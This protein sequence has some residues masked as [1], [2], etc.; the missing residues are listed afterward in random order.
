M[1]KKIQSLQKDTARAQAAAANLQQRL[2]AITGLYREEMAYRLRLQDEYSA[3]RGHLFAVLKKAMGKKAEFLVPKSLYEQ[4]YS[5]VNI[6]TEGDNFKFEFA[7]VE[8]PENAPEPEDH[9][10]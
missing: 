4:E 1:S 8:V 7:P 9:T 5:G 2:A 3:L 6:R 10:H